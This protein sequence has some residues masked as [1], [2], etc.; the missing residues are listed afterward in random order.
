MRLVVFAAFFLTPLFAQSAEG[1]RQMLQTLISE[2]QQLRLAIERS[3]LLG[4]RTQI[5]MQRIQ[6]QEVR[7]WRLVQELERVRKEI[8]EIQSRQAHMT[9]R[10]KE[11]EEQASQMTDP[12]QRREMTNE[13]KRLKHD[14]ERMAAL[15][16]QRR[17]REAELI[18]QVQSE[19]G[20]LTE[21]QDR[22]GDMERALDTAIRQVTG[23]K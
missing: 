13:A 10:S 15:E 19:Q 23:G 17:V 18:S 1:D 16:Q 8:S 6:T 21:L 22:V 12:N 4:T 2:V 3:T 5:T 20:R 9:Q 11:S 14:M 7:T